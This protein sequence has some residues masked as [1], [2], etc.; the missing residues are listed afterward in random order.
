M[1]PSSAPEVVLLFLGYKSL[2]QLYIFSAKPKK[3]SNKSVLRSTPQKEQFNRFP[4]SQFF[5][6][7]NL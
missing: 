5:V 3:M 2:E 7:R 4:L 1:Y 6:G